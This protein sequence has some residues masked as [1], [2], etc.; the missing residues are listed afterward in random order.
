MASQL[1]G[2]IN[3]KLREKI[4]AIIIVVMLIDTT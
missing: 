2:R 1:E 4:Q 3:E